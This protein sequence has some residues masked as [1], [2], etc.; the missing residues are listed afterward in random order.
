MQLC[1]T[2]AGMGGAEITLLA[3]AKFGGPELPSQSLDVKRPRCASGSA[4]SLAL[5][6]PAR[7]ALLVVIHQARPDIIHSNGLWGAVNHWASRT[8]RNFSIPLVIQPH[9]MLAP[10]ALSHRAWKK[11]LAMAL[12]QKRDLES[13]K[14]FV[15]TSIAEYENIRRLGFRQPIAVVPNGIDLAVSRTIGSHREGIGENPRL[16]LFL[17]RI[18]PVKGLLNLVRAWGQLVPE[19]WR[20]CLA[21]PDQGGHLAEV[22]ALA[23][24]LEIDHLVDYVG[25]LDG[26]DKSSLYNRADLFVL[27]SFTE[28]FGVVVAEALAHGVPVIASKGTP[29]AEL[30]E[31]N[32]GWWVDIGV[33]PLA[34]ALK[35]A[36]DLTPE[37]RHAM[38]QRGRRLVAQNYSWDKIGKDMLSVYEWVLEGGAPP[39]CVITD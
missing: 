27:P 25:E 23:R 19:G 16:V 18:H 24:K 33:E 3:Q 12:Y 30:E 17:G 11:N 26:A 13:A 31:H 29:W 28:N 8:A 39:S 35:E 1:D 37:E 38:G 15:A 2:M 7:S 5:G 22:M 20:L 32:C 14:L 4:L 6:L 34:K 10:W 36:T 21:G 9:G